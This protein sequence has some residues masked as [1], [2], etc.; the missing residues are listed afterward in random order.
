EVYIVGAGPGDPELLTFKALRLMQQADIVYYDALVSPQVL[1]LCRR[2]AD[3]VFV[4]KKRSNHAVAQL[5]I[6]E[7]LI[8][9]AKQGRR[10][11]RLKGGDPFIFGR[12][13]EEIESLRAHEVPY[14]VVPGITAANAA[15]S[16]AGIPLT[17]RDHS[18]SVRFVTGFLKAGAPNEKFENLLDTNETVVFYMGLHSLARLTTGLINAGRSPET[19]IAIVSNASM[20]NQQVLTGTLESIVA[21]QEQ[22]QLPTPALLIMG[23]VVALH[24]DLAWYNKHNKDTGDTETNW[25]RAGTA[26][27]DQDAK[28]PI[29]QQA[30]ALS[31]IANLAAQQEEGL[32]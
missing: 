3:K 12:G 8:N 30:H 29:D 24:D 10:V 32:E 27:T 26:I 4:G 2:D 28:K 1:D 16:Y 5:G 19:P 11:V 6:N 14:Q 15:A 17:H 20:P 7:L 31:M 9:S 13:G 25:L 23:D 18:Q 22:N 21:L